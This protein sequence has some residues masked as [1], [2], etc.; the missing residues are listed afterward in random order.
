M[1]RA[2]LMSGLLL[3][4]GFPAAEAQTR[5]LVGRVNDSTLNEPVT[6]GLI[7]VMGT[8]IQ[9]QVRPD[10]TF[11]LYT[12]IRE[13][14]LSFESRGYKKKEVR[15]PQSDETV[16]IPVQRDVFELSQMV[17]TGQGTGVE[18]R[19]LANAVSRVNGEDLVRTPAGTID[20]A[21][22]GKVTGA[23]FSNTAGGA[24]GGGLALRLRGVT[25]ILGNNDPMFIVDG[26]VVSNASI[27]SGINA[28]TRGQ[29]GVIASSQESMVNR[30]SDINP[31][32]IESIE[33]LKGAAASAMYGSKASNGVVIITTKRGKFRGEN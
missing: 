28:V 7:R 13:V 23:N 16:I 33:I 22:R 30:I 32:D 5:L 10:G 19:N 15:V 3:V 4:A 31:N 8:P 12:P 27:P 20:E 24:P 9:A 14:T 21:M 25:T 17:V 1:K 18:R 29:A 6:G 11:I 26:I 2:W